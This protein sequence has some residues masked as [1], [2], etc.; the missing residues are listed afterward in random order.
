LQSAHAEKIVNI[1][2][3]F[4][5]ADLVNTLLHHEQLKAH[6]I[7]CFSLWVPWQ[8]KELLPNKFY[9][10]ALVLNVF[11][12]IL[13]AIYVKQSPGNPD[14]YSSSKTAVID[15]Y[16]IRLFVYAF[17]ITSSGDAALR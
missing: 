15:V 14:E 9:P 4:T 7:C 16:F 12:L 10:V 3:A 1:L 17:N 6:E 13:S 8:T 5:I 2:H 11:V